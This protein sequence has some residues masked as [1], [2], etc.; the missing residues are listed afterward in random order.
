MAHRPIDE[1]SDG[2]MRKKDERKAEELLVGTVE[3]QP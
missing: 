2:S 1:Q 3:E